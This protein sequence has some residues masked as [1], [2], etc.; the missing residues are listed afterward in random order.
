MGRLGRVI[1]LL[2]GGALGGCS[3]ADVLN[4]LA[5]DA[6]VSVRR[7]IAYGAEPGQ[8][9]DLYSPEPP[10]SGAPI[11]V[12]FHGGGWE[13]G[14]P[15]GYRFLGTALARQG[16]TVVVA[17][18]RLYPAV[19]YPGFVED[20]ALA[21]RWAHDS[22]APEGRVFVMGHSAGAYIAAMLALDP[23]WLGAVGLR[24]GRDLAGMIGLSGPYDFL[25]LQSPTLRTIFGP[26]AERPATQPIRYVNAEAPPIFLATGCADRVV[27]PANTTRLAAAQRTVGGS[28][29]TSAY[30]GIG[31]VLTIG[32]FAGPL[33]FTAPVLAE[34]LAFL[35]DPG[36]ATGTTAGTAT[37]AAPPA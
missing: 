34:T 11:V 20:G 16:V 5:S 6:G 2:L 9:L 28:V 17:G 36:A 12:F 3:G 14:T 7:D 29:S 23:R 32:A 33:R 24:P 15:G 1:A 18:Y 21:V 31:H 8:R 35:R 22:L 30:S 25:P 4:G 37:C 19:R 27:D 10:E 26:E 13:S